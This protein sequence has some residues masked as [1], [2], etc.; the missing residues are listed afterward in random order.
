MEKATYHDGL[1]RRHRVETYCYKD[2]MLLAISNGYNRLPSL[3]GGGID[4][5]ESIELAGLRELSEEAGWSGECPEIIT[6]SGDWV[7]DVRDD[8]W[9]KEQG[10]HQEAQYAVKCQSLSFNTDGRYGSENDHDVYQWLSVEQV[11]VETNE[12]LR[13]PTLPK[14]K[15][16]QANFRMA[17]LSIL[18]P[19]VANQPM[20]KRW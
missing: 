16:M 6:P 13:D 7:L 14:R 3:P 15:R 10:W 17:V 20:F 2:D 18:H 1:K 4:V 12:C 8:V 11:M 5:N 19:H 9:L